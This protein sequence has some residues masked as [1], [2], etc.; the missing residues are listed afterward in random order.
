[1]IFHRH[2]WEEKSITVVEPLVSKGEAEARMSEHLFRQLISG[3][4]TYIMR[5]KGCGDL[6]TYECLGVVEP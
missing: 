4:T 6:K 1:M 2:K 5:C 3:T